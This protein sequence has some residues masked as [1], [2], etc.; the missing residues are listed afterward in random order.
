M[1]WARKNRTPCSARQASEHVAEV[2]AVGI[3]LRLT[4][5][6]TQPPTAT[7]RRVKVPSEGEPLETWVPVWP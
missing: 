1:L 3:E 4:P 6:S 5:G 7:H 2:L